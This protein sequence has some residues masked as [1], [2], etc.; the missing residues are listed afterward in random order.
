M[1]F[2]IIIILIVLILYYYLMRSNTE[3][4]DNNDAV[5]LTPIYTYTGIPL[6]FN[7]DPT[8]PD[9]NYISIKNLGLNV[10]N[11]SV[12]TNEHITHVNY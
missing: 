1:K 5:A 9:F 7:N 12:Y 11:L 3:C 4:F 6:V 8:D 10:P 2:L